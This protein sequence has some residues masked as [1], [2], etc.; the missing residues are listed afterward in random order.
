VFV[1]TNSLRLRSFVGLRAPAPSVARR[2]ERWALR[3]VFVVLVGLVVFAGVELQRNLLPCRAV[4]ITLQ[5]GSLTPEV[6]EVR[7]GEKLTFELYTDRAASFVL[8]DGDTPTHEH[9]DAHRTVGTVVPPDT[10]VRLTWTL[11]G[12]SDA[13]EGMRLVEIT[14][15]TEVPLRVA[16]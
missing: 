13:L 15:G 2:V 10:R 7:P 6:I 9:A 12:D 8:V 1:V 4:P 3:A 14:T 16:R 5:D 11:P